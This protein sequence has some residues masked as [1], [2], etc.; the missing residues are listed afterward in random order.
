MGAA[1]A[2]EEVTLP[3]GLILEDGARIGAVTLRPLTGQEEAWLA[4]RFDL[5]SAPVVTHLLAACLA[6]DGRPVPP[7]LAG[8]LLVGDRDYLMLRLRRLTLGD[9]VAAVLTCP[10]CRARMDLTIDLAEAPV[11]GPPQT[12]EWQ[13]LELPD[14]KQA[15]RFRL[16]TGADQEAVAHLDEREAVAALLRRCLRDESE[17]LSV[18]EAARLIEA[19]EEAAPRVEI[20]LDL[21]CPECGHAFLAPFDAT[22]F[23]LA[24]MRMSGER[25]L[26][27]VHQ[28]AF[29]YGWSEAEILGLE[30]VR[31]RAYLSLLDDELRR[32]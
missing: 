13:R 31:R 22:A 17:A 8:R 28:L 24:E 2:T 7:G 3:G 19:M 1:L 20:E 29:H 30:R 18:E 15:V 32:E 6:I 5:P 12:Q 11:E 27:E 23:F 10:S 9:V 4:D 21:T 26:R 16:P 25:L 14:R